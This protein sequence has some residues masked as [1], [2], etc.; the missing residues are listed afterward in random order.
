MLAGCSQSP[1]TVT[2]THS[3]D[4][5][6]FILQSVADHGGHARTTNGLPA[7]QSQWRT[8]VLTGAQYLDDR[9]QVSIIITGDHFRQVT[10]YLAQ[11]FGTP[12]QPSTLHTNDVI[13]GWYAMRDV[14]IGLQFYRDQTKTGLILVGQLKK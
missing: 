13:H 10:G 1:K 8:E 2:T 7:L 12:S 14:G 4:L 6:Q 5:G 11:A 3:G 9:E